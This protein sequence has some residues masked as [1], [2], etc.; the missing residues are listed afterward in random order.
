M[1]INPNVY[2]IP[3]SEL[4][5]QANFLIKRYHKEIE[6]IVDPPIPVEKMAEFLL[7]L[8]IDWVPISDDDD[9]PV[10][11]FIDPESNSIRIN[12][13][14][15][16]FFNK[17]WGTQQYTLAHEIGHYI[18]RLTHNNFQQMSFEVDDR[19]PYLCRQQNSKIDRREFQAEKFGSFLL[20][21]AQ[22]LLPKYEHIDLTWSNLYKLRDEFSVSIT[23]LTKRLKNMGYLH[24]DDDKKL[25]RS[26]NEAFGQ[27]RMFI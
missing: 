12:E 26:E 21:P 16:D 13:N 1:K 6:P 5:R 7:D 18:F 2:F 3:D 15:N 25:F 10:L 17:F 27:M 23:A 9:A 11:A 8:V 4:E 22:L 20:M 19:K 24:I 14:R